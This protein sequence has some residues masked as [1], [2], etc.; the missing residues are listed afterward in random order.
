MSKK[1]YIYEHLEWLEIF[2]RKDWNDPT[3]NPDDLAKY[4]ELQRPYALPEGEDSY[5]AWEWTWPDINF[6]DIPPII[7]VDPIEDPCSVD[8]GCEWA[9]IFGAAEIKCGDT[10]S[11]TQIHVWIGCTV[12]PW[13]AAFGGWELE[14]RQPDLVILHDGLVI[15]RIDVSDDA[16]PETVLLTYRGVD[17]CVDTME[18]VITDC[19]VCCDPFTLTGDDT[20]NASATWTGTIDPSCAG[21]ECG[22]TSNSGCTLT[23]NVNEAGSQVT[24][25]VGGGDCGS[26]TVT[27]TEPEGCEND[28]ASKTVRINGG[29]AGWVSHGESTH[30]CGSCP[31]GPNGWRISISSC[32]EGKF[33]YGGGGT[34]GFNN[35]AQL[36]YGC[37]PTHC[38]EA[39][40]EKPPCGGYPNWGSCAEDHVSLTGF[41]AG[42]PI[43]GCTHWR[44]STCE[45]KCSC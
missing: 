33:R 36:C 21:A 30:S 32:T 27:V 25:G 3:V 1:P 24:V 17:N 5:P 40:N 45:W 44:F 19:E 31:H 4:S 12:A 42:G 20:V 34:C 18:V 2:Q 35:S 26:F 29:G 22:V 15:A 13:W 7:K 16:E 37:T 23:C 41:C 6:P 8:E 11:Y 10:A 39:E 14:T 28:T 9:K 38:A 43:Q